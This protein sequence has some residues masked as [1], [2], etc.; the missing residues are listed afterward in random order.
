MRLSVRVGYPD[1][2][3]HNNGGPW[4]GQRAMKNPVLHK[5]ETSYEGIKLKGIGAERGTQSERMGGEWPVRYTKE[6]RAG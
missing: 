6:E 5:Y 1:E 3:V 4:K 2:D